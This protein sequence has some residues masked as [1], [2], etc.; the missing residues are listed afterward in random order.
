MPHQSFS[1]A[2]SSLCRFDNGHPY[3]AQSVA[4]TK[5]HV[6]AQGFFYRHR[7]NQARNVARKKLLIASFGTGPPRWGDR[8]QSTGAATF[9]FDP[10]TRAARRPPATG[11]AVKKGG[12]AGR[13]GHHPRRQPNIS[14]RRAGINR[15]GGGGWPAD[16]GRSAGKSSAPPKGLPFSRKTPP[17]AAS[18]R[19]RVTTMA[20]RP[21]W[22]AGPYDSYG[23][24]GGP[25]GV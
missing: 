4:N 7:R 1:S 5:G 23:Y 14:A 20:A 24:Y 21:I 9:D 15:G 12:S 16:G 8:L 10:S 3:C 25:P 11:S 19:N 22:P 2:P 17:S 13:P 6:Q 18:P